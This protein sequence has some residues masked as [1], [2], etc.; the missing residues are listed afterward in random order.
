MQRFVDFTERSQGRERLLR[1]TQYTC[2]LLSYVLQRQAEKE[3]L[4]LKLKQLEASMSSG[5]KSKLCLCHCSVQS[6]MGPEHTQA[7]KMEQ[8]EKLAT[9]GY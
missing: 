1:A 6:A 4:V 9:P 5:R 7:L 2:M 3:E 8:Q